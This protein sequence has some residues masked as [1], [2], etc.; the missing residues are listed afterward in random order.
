MRRFE[1]K[2]GPCAARAA[3]TELSGVVVDIILIGMNA[4]LKAGHLGM[5]GRTLVVIA[6]E[7]KATADQISG[8]AKTLQPVLDRIEQS[9]TNPRAL[10]AA[11]DPSTMARLEPV[12]VSAMAEIEAG[13]EKLEDLME[14]LVAQ[15][16][17][18]ERMIAHARSILTYLGAKVGSFPVTARSLESETIPFISSDEAA[19]LVRCSTIFMRTTRW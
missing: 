8:G 4:G 5:R 19:C 6:G 15:G 16:G 1:G 3:M 14:R 11:S 17:E 9:A 2:L 18:F 13:N 10:R 12:V 7:L